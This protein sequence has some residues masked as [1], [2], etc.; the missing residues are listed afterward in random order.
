M[1]RRD[2]FGVLAGIASVPFLGKLIS[3]KENSV[4]LRY[5]GKLSSDVGIYYAPYVPQYVGLKKGEMHV[6]S[7][8]G[9]GKSV[10]T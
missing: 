10:L 6:I 2:F 3:K 5:K 8:S 7:A 1:K 4:G 9:T